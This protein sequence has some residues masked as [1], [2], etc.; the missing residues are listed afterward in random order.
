M[1]EPWMRANYSP[2]N[3]MLG[4]P[5]LCG[6]FASKP[7]LIQTGIC[8][9]VPTSRLLVSNR[10]V[11]TRAFIGTNPET[12]LPFARDPPSN[13]GSKHGHS[14]QFRQADIAVLMDENRVYSV[15]L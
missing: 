4:I 11:S 6:S 9:L 14:F 7:E 12:L 5:R 13:G 1:S 3:V 2:R 10:S 15:L 8:G